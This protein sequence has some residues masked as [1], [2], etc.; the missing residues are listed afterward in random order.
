MTGLLA[1]PLSGYPMNDFR[2]NDSDETTKNFRECQMTQNVTDK[3]LTVNPVL[4]REN[5]TTN[6]LMRVNVLNVL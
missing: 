4:Y 6:S 3:T 2:G 5:L 1:K